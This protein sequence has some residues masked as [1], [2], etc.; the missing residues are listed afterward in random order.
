[1]GQVHGVH[2]KYVAASAVAAALASYVQENILASALFLWCAITYA[3][4]AVLFISR[5]GMGLIGKNDVTGQVPNW[6]LAVWGAF[7][8]FN[9]L[10]TSINLVF[11]SKHGM[12]I[13]TEVE[14]GWWIGGR[15]C[16]ALKKKWALTID[17]TCEFP[18]GCRDTSTE[19]L[20]LPCW[21]G[22]PPTPE[23]IERA[24]QAAVRCAQHGAVMV[25][26]A[27]GKGRSTTVMAA[28][29]VRAG[30]YSTWLEAFEAIKKKRP[31]VSLNKKMRRALSAWQQRYC[32]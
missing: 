22:V 13:A 18:E 26:C 12:G 1:M 28:C 31:V 7:H 16:V 11:F 20:L 15:Y 14:P 8:L 21:D 17:L 27:H 23:Q 25:H 9:W 6:S 30:Y 32:A 5:R 24:A 2:L 29:L 19:Y 3:I 4:V 10:Y